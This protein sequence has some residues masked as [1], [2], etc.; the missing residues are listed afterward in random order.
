MWI[1]DLSTHPIEQPAIYLA[2]NTQTVQMGREVVLHKL[3]VCSAI[4]GPA[5]IY[6]TLDAGTYSFQY[7]NQDLNIN[8]DSS[9]R[10]DISVRIIEQPKHG[11]LVQK[12]SEAIDYT[13]NHY[14]YIPDVDYGDYDYFVMEAKTGDITVQIY[15]TMSVGLS[16]EPTYAIGENGERIDDVERCAKPYW[17]IS[18]PSST[19]P[20]QLTYTL[21]LPAGLA[22]YDYVSPAVTFDNLTGSAVGETKGEGATST[23]TLDTDAALR[24]V[25]RLHPVP[26]RRLPAHH[27]PN[28]WV[29]KTGS[30]AASYKS[31]Q[32]FLHVHQQ[33]IKSSKNNFDNK[34]SHFF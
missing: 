4:N 34:T 21:N 18:Q 16:G 24:L 15:Y 26:Q 10:T 13:R 2:A 14:Q 27:N 7:L 20:A 31:N 25:H 19:S 11:R 33:S 12:Y 23:I 30:G 17:K 8:P 32:E 29:A 6:P 3:G 28:E 5:N 1:P 22:G 9:E